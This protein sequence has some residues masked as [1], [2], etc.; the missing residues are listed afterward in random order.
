[1]T[2]ALSLTG[3]A[4]GAV[5]LLALAFFSPGL[6]T[7]GIWGY[8]LFVLGLLTFVGLIVS[9]PKHRWLCA[10]ATVQ[11]ILLGLALYETFSDAALYVGT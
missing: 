9:A 6:R 10:L 4:L 7:E 5:P 8:A 1:M 3:F 11:G 2:H